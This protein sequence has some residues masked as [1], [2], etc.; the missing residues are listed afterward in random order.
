M[1]EFR[2]NYATKEWVIVAPNRNARPQDV[3]AE[4]SRPGTAPGQCPFCPG[5]EHETGEE[6]LR[7]DDRGAWT[8]RVVRNKFSALDSMRSPHRI[9]HGKF[10]KSENYGAGE[11]II[12]SPMHDQRLHE[13]S[14]TQIELILRAFRARAI[15]AANAPDMA[16]VMIFRNYGA[17]AGTSLV[18]PHSQIIASPSTRWRR[19]RARRPCVARSRKPCRGFGDQRPRGF[20]PLPRRGGECSLIP[21][22]SQSIISR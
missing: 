15:A 12:E 16:I 10:L 7:Y 5:N 1:S 9:P 18:H 11:V 2:Q 17:H 13:M 8:L 6:L 20:G 4:T 19:K 21:G 3:G 14:V 22:M